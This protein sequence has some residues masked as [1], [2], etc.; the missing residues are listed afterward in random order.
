EF[1]CSFTAAVRGAYYGRLM[2]QA[3]QDGRITE[4]PYEPDL[5]VDTWWDLGV[6]D[7]T[8]IWF[9][10][11][12]GR[13][14]CVIDYYEATGEGLKH[15]AEVLQSKGYVYGQHVGPHDLKV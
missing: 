9:V 1:E 13:Q 10:Q 7:P 5:K 14:V 4:V 3:D 15:Y 11:R 6:R 2:A 12:R 8:A